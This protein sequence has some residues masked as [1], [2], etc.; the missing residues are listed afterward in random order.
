MGDQEP[1]YTE[2][3]IWVNT[4]MINLAI[5]HRLVYKRWQK[6]NTILQPKDT[7]TPKIHRLRSL[8][9]YEADLNM[10][11]QIVFGRK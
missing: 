11:L 9:I 4:M 5:K 7:R 6:V 2:K 1:G 8:N 3:F 10:V